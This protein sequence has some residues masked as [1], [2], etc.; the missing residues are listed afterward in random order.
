MGYL[1]KLPDDPKQL[2]DV[3][4]KMVTEGRGKRNPEQVRWFINSFYMR[5][6]RDFTDVNYQNGTI[7][8]AWMNEAGILKFRL[9]EITS[10]YQA[11]LGRLESVDLSP[12]VSP[13]GISLDGLRKSSVGQVALNA[14]FPQDK[15]RQ[16]S[17][18]LCPPILLYGTVG[19]VLWVE[20]EDSM[21][22]EVVMPWELFPLPVDVSG[23]TDV[24]GLMRVRWVPRQ[25]VEDLMITKSKRSSVWKG[26]SS[27]DV[28]TGSMPDS[29]L[30]DDGSGLSM[31]SA[32]GGYYT[33][34]DGSGM[35]RDK[36]G[37]KDETNTKMVQLVEVW[38]ETAD[39]YL[40]EYVILAGVQ[41]LKLLH[42]M[43]HSQHKYPMPIRIIRDVTVSSFWG[44]SFV[45]QLIPLNHEAE[46]AMSSLF[47]TLSDFDLYG[48]QIWP[49][50]LGVPPLAE[51]GQDGIK[52]IRFEPDYT[53][54]ELR[55]D[56]IMPA[57]MSSA[58]VDVLRIAF[59]VMNRV[60]NQ[61][62]ELLGGGAPGRMDALPGL[63]FLYETSGIPLSP[64]TKSMAEA[65]S[66]VYRAMLR[67]IKDMWSDQKA[68][69]VSQLDDTLAGIVLDTESGTMSL[70][71]NSIPYP[72][73]VHVDVAS[74]VPVSKEQQKME[75][76][77]ALKD[78]RITL[79]E[80]V[81]QVRKRGLDLPVGMEVE[82]H[83]YQRAVLNN[84]IL[85]GDG[86]TPGKVMA[87]DRDLHR[88]HLQVLDAFMSRPAFY[89][90]SAKVR[91]AFIELYDEHRIGLGAFPDAVPMP[92]DSAEMMLGQ[93]PGPQMTP[94]MPM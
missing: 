94:E 11:Q 37:K 41:N 52:R 7:S 74:A 18:A 15:V 78:S 75:L 43:N 1:F 14:A 77:E 40:N 58:Q 13:R 35:G 86:E 50:T 3:V 48:L 91:A 38:T 12:A 70:A 61:P 30:L 31:T 64:T 21:G 22:I 16:L 83:N 44:R 71:S 60:S 81:F 29:A 80:F 66:G 57:K 2:E 19:V 87:S 28:P 69:S 36:S 26:V 89:S 8:V 68:V 54:P 84:I 85:F 92:E 63:N 59:D 72:D 33:V 39:G 20:G 42:R 27:V 32:G 24:R 76:K 17:L 73:E 55:P 34:S 65:V 82:W 9:D 47:E 93:F 10:K 23:P 45:D 51:R 4:G 56:N 5:G 6:C 49:T 25:W 46:L 90:A 88:I 53:S 62:T 79:E 67:I